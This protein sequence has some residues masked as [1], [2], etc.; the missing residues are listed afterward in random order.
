MYKP[1]LAMAANIHELHVEWIGH[2]SNRSAPKVD[3]GV[4]SCD[5][6]CKIRL[7]MPTRCEINAIHEAAVIAAVIETHNALTGSAFVIESRPNPPDAVIADGNSRLWIE[8]TDAFYSSDWARDLTSFA[9]SDKKHIHLDTGVHVDMDSTL[10]EKFCSVV[11]KK[12]SNSSYAP[13]AEEYG[14]GIMVVG[15]ETPWLSN[16]TIDSI[17]RRWKEIGSPDLSSVFHWVYLGFRSE[18]E[19]RAILW[20]PA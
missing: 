13:L 2:S 9:A 17:N 14:P 6:Q 8:H 3:A 7:S 15:L 1:A 20:E 18:G 11:L 5:R 4:V 12:L 10:A 19:N 16:D